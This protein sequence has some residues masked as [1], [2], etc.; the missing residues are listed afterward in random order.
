MI[1]IDFVRAGKFAVS[2]PHI[3]SVQFNH[4]GSATIHTYKNGMSTS[5]PGEVRALRE[6]IGEIPRSSGAPDQPADEAQAL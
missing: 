5:D 4:D 2:V 3:A 1:N 6:L